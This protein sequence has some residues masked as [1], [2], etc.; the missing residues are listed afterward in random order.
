[1]FII[2]AGGTEPGRL[3][4]SLP[5][6]KFSLNCLT[7]CIASELNSFQELSQTQKC[8]NTEVSLGLDLHIFVIVT[9]GHQPN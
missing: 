1:M 9:C 5:A 4:D 2:T 3:Y 8:S 6:I 7:G